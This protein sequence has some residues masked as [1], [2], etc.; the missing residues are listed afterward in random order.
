MTATFSGS[1]TVSVAG[2]LLNTASIGTSGYN[3]NYPKTLDYANGTGAS[4]AN[5]VWTDTRT[6]AASATESLDLAGSLS[7]AF[8]SIVTFTAIK[9]IIISASSGNT[10][11]VIVGGAASNA[12]INWVGDATDTVIIQPAGTF[13]LM[14]SKAGGYPVTASTGDILKITNSSSGS[15]VTYDIIL[16]GNV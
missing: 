10:N 2:T 5:M 15:S 1:V 9:G 12:F 4:M 13:C 16:L 11:N 7:N 14:T 6:L 3:I 8:G